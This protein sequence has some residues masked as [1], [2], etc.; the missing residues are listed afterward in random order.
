MV[1]VVLPGGLCSVVSPEL[2]SVA[3][4]ELCSLAQSK[5]AAGLQKIVKVICRKK[6]RI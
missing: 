4:P 5:L 1:V 6:D 2:C 3:S